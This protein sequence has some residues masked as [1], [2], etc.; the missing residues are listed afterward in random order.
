MELLDIDIAGGWGEAKTVA[1]LVGGTQRAAKRAKMYTL[2][3]KN[4]IL[5]DQ[6]SFKLWSQL[7]GNSVNYLDFFNF[8][9]S[10]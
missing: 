3:E 2:N 4:L 7:K 10:L 5:C 8:I 9:I 1:T 6:Q